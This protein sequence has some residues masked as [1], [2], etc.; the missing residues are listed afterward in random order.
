LGWTQQRS[1]Y[2]NQRLLPTVILNLESRGGLKLHAFAEVGG[3]PAAN[4]VFPSLTSRL[5]TVY[6]AR[7]G[8]KRIMGGQKMPQE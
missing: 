7:G 3:S 6:N 1:D 5:F 8:E 4:P 2:S